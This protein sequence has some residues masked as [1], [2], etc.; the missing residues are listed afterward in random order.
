[1]PSL[2]LAAAAAF[3]LIA[4]FA[5]AQAAPSPLET[6]FLTPPDD[7]RILMRWWW[8]G[9]AVTKAELDREIR[10]MKAGGIGGF[11]VQPVYPLALDGHPP[12]LRNLKFLSPEFLDDLGF[13]AADAKSLGLRMDLTLGSGWPYGGPMFDLAENA[14]ALRVQTALAGPGETAVPLPALRPAEALIGAYLGPAPG[15]EASTDRYRDFYQP[16]A[17]AGGQARLPDG[18]K[19]P[20]PVL[21]FIASHTGMKV[22]RAAYGAEGYVLDHY[23]GDAVQKFIA[24]VAG[25]ELAACGPNLPYSTFC[26]SLE[27]FNTDWTGNL[28]AEF[29]RRRGYDLAPHLPALVADDGPGTEGIRHD[30]GETLTEV[31]GDSFVAPLQAWSAAHGTQFRIQA[32]GTPPAALSTYAQAGLPEGEGWLWRQF[33][34]TRWASSASHLL[35]KPVT[36]SETWTWLHSP[37]FRATPLDMKAAADTYFLQGSNQLIGH[38]WPYTPPGIPYP[39]WRFYAAAVFDEKNPWWIVMPDVARYLQRVSFLLRQGEPVDDVALYLPEHDAWS[40]FTAGKVA[41][42][43]AVG[44]DLGPDIVGAI[45]DSGHDLDFFDD[46][47]LA[48]RG[49]V[50]GGALAFGSLRYRAV[51]LPGIASIPLDTLRA[52]DR[53]ARGG[54]LLVATRR[55]P[56]RVPGF[57]ATEADQAELRA[58]VKKLFTDPGAPGIFVPSED[59]LAAAINRRLAPDVEFDA[60]QTDLGFVHRHLPDADLYFVANTG[61]RRVEA[62]AVFR[63]DRTPQIWDPMTGQVT[64]ADSRESADGRTIVTLGLPAYGSTV[65]VFSGPARPS[66]PR[67]PTPFI[68]ESVGM[69]RQSVDLSDNWTIAF[70]AGAPVPLPHLRSWTADPATEHFS[71]VAVYERSVSLRQDLLAGAVS[72]RLDFGE[73]KPIAAPPGF[74]GRYQTRLQAPLRDAAIVFV[75]GRRVGSVWCPPYS[76]DV[77]GFVHAGENRL[78]IEV[79][80]LALNALAGQPPPDYGPLQARF[81]VRFEAQDMSLVRPEPA[82]LL[83]P[84]SLI[85]SRSPRP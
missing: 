15:A 26:D 63:D 78:R 27:V 3:V 20:A 42:S 70:G 77:S 81:G 10:T 24:R 84:V 54:G 13:V 44:R 83:G 59:R 57:A 35:G 74:R 76:I 68:R 52:L 56:D 17:I 66:G 48:Q 16:I 40:Q 72:L 32:Y 19:G 33:Q 38:G 80:N 82:G 64:S 2:R 50:D 23:S 65:Y 4:P 62:P 34:P 31:F 5:G 1:M 25:P 12:G 6:G 69:V 49:R 61:N 71:G 67:Q 30:W 7:S 14:G 37:V 11:E 47:L 45:L 36:S 18:I 8:F 79:A 60:A 43:T 46:G 75:N 28:L 53:F 21:F 58:L 85:V 55:L 22:K 51:V 9:P 41:L 39:G 29:R 73:A